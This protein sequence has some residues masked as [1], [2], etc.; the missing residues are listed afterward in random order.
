MHQVHW[1][2]YTQCTVIIWLNPI[3]W[4]TFSCDIF[5]EEKKHKIASQM[6]CESN[7]ICYSYCHFCRRNIIFFYRFILYMKI[8]WAT[9]NVRTS[10]FFPLWQQTKCFQLPSIIWTEIHSHFFFCSWWE[11]GLW[12]WCKTWIKCS[13]FSAFSHYNRKLIII[14]CVCWAA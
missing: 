8:Y 1:L 3:H 12:P 7:I 9:H 6:K 5:G 14:D 10:F 13:I 2:F 11:V 4:N